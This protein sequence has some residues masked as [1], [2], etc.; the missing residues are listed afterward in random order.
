MSVWKR[1]G[2][3]LRGP[4]NPAG[5][6]EIGNLDAEGMLVDPDEN[7][8]EVQPEPPEPEQSPPSPVLFRGKKDQLAAVEDGFTKLVD[9]LESMNENV[10][11]HRRQ[12]AGMHSKIESLAES[13]ENL[14]GGIAEQSQILRGMTD[15]IKNQ[16]FKHQQLSEIIKDL[17]ESNREQV[18]QLN[19]IVNNLESS[20]ENQVR[21]VES[22]NKFDVSVNGMLENSRAQAASLSNI[23]DMLENSQSHLQDM[24]NK[25]NK[26]F[27][28]LLGVTVAMAVA[29]IGAVVVLAVMIL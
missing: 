2:G 28:W 4:H 7:P 16:S 24:V 9:V 25:Q 26:R 17:P 11:M 5:G 29:V 3:W 19:C 21:Q 13:L 20:L 22:F 8:P 10:L 15:E 6:D 27:G 1:M 14:P 18:E 12:S 23:G